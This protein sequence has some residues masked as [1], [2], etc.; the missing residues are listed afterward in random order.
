MIEKELYEVIGSC[1]R[2]FQ[3]QFLFETNH[4]LIW[5]LVS[6]KR[7]EGDFSAEEDLESM[8]HRCL[9]IIYDAEA[10]YSSYLVLNRWK[11]VEDSYRSILE[12]LEYS[13]GSKEPQ[14]GKQLTREQRQMY[15]DFVNDFSFCW[16]CE[17]QPLGPAVTNFHSGW[18]PLENSHIV[19]GAGRRAD[20]RSLL[21][22]CRLHH[23]VFDGHTIRDEE[24][25]AMKAITIENA[26][27][28]KQKND[29]EFYDLDFIKSLR[30]K[31]FEPIKPKP[32][33]NEQ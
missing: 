20:R 15:K 2:V 9:A 21:R 17:H 19:G 6:D 32:I 11:Y 23:M 7:L 5:W 14:M 1:N 27:W 30:H 28:L 8:F 18:N 10:A 24:G 4:A 13:T 31:R 29:E 12:P 25:E 33:R 22:L 16:L 26:L 3:E